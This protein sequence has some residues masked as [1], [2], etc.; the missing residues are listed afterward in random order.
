[1]TTLAASSR[2]PS[3]P[4]AKVNGSA[5]SPEP[6][7]LILQTTTLLFA[8]AETTERTVAA[9]NRVAEVLGYRATLIP[10]WDELT[11]RL[12]GSAGSEH[13][14]AAVA[15]AGI[16]MNKVLA[17]E[18]TIDAMTDGRLQPEEARSAFAKIAA[19]PPVSLGRFAL[20]A[21]GGD[22]APG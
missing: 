1:M 20:A 10:R 21:A 19:F 8:N 11:I 4:E 7:A 3:S 9:G 16:D 15:P 17:T 13:D 6:L 2:D 12:E 22:V 5:S 18:Q 14:V